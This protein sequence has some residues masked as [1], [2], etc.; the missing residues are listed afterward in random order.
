MSE[1]KVFHGVKKLRAPERL[2][3]LEVDRA[4]SESLHDLGARTVLDIGTGSGI[5]AEAFAGRGLRVTG[6]DIQEEMLEAART[7]VPGA[8]FERAASEDLPFA[9]GSFDLCFLG[10]VLHETDRP[11]RAIEEACRACRMRTAVLEWPVRQQPMGPPLELRWKTEDLLG[12]A[13]A[14]GFAQVRAVPL[15]HLTLFLFDKKSDGAGDR[16]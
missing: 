6:I 4:V 3:F 1:E 15:T 5:F 13:T 12:L 7:F 2:A 10:L 14:A 11:R 16:G 9:D 8:R